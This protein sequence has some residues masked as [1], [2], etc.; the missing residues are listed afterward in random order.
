MADEVDFLTVSNPA[1]SPIT[2][3]VKTW[4]VEEDEYEKEAE[5]AYQ[6][7]EMAIL[8]RQRGEIHQ[9]EA[10]RDAREEERD[11]REA[12]R[13]KRE[14]ERDASPDDFH[15]GWMKR[16]ERARERKTREA[17]RDTREVERD[18]REEERERCKKLADARRQAEMDRREDERDKREAERDRLVREVDLHPYKA[19]RE[20][21]V[22]LLQAVMVQRASFDDHS[23]NDDVFPDSYIKY[24]SS[25]L[26]DEYLSDEFLSN[27]EK[28]KIIE[29]KAC[30]LYTT[31]RP[32]QGPDT[33]THKKN[34]FIY[35]KCVD[36]AKKEN[37][38]KR[39]EKEEKFKQSD[40]GKIIEKAC[41][42]YKE[43]E[44]KQGT[45]HYRAC[46]S[47]QL[48]RIDYSGCRIH[49]TQE[50]INE[51]ILYNWLQEKNKNSVIF[52]KYVNMA[53][54]EMERECLEKEEKLKRQKLNRER[55]KQ[56]KIE[57][58]ERL[59]QER[60]EQERLEQE[61]L[62]KQE[63]LEKARLEEKERLEK[64]RRLEEKKQFLLKRFRTEYPTLNYDEVKHIDPEIIEELETLIKKLSK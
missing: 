29:K 49:Q 17:L 27:T 44:P 11:Q 33:D 58:Q 14:E 36:M 37:K 48:A 16:T 40:E 25:Y 31:Q 34:S 15:D 3:V 45:G 28:R 6:L 10:E 54:K 18:K 21:R 41:E 20:N 26:S 46:W 5:R 22:T 63:S 51:R 55:L 13:D 7:T 50:Q 8:D 24:L 59:E 53:K 38:Q 1:Q 30:E 62:E 2:E 19:N 60:L 4:Q 12:D 32:K 42:L 61:R 9:R 52:K 35:K 64:P 39:L 47:D 57:L 43:N 56:E 23:E